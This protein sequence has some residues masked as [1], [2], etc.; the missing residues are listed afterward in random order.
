MTIIDVLVAVY[1]GSLF[2]KLTYYYVE[3]DLD[4]YYLKKI[5]K[6]C[7]ITIRD[8]DADDEDEVDL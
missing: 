8:L 6:D 2:A 5:S 3:K 4:R 7:Y 1:L